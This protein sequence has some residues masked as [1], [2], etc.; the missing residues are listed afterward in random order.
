MTYGT[1]RSDRCRVRSRDA[2]S[3]LAVGEQ[4]VDLLPHGK[5]VVDLLPVGEQ[6]E[7]GGSAV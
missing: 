4:V 6:P 7:D 3:V 2:M 5:Q 1:V